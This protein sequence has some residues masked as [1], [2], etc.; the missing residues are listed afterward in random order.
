MRIL[1]ADD[2]AI[3][4]RLL[5]GT[6]RRLGHEIVAVADGVAARDALLAEGGP[7]LAILD[8]MMPGL[9]GLEVC[10]AV[11][12]SEGPYVYVILLTARA[13]RE[14][15]VA[16]LAAQA[17][18][19]LTKPFNVAELQARIQSGARIVDLQSSLLD[20]Q[21]ALRHEA[22]HDR[23]T[24][25]WNRGMIIDHLSRELA[26]EERPGGN[27]TVALVDLDHFKQINDTH[28]HEAGDEVLKETARRM[29]AALRD[30]DAAGRY[31]GEE[32]LVV[33]GAADGA[34]GLL[35]A[36]RV[37]VAIGAAPI[38]IRTTTVR[39]T[40]SVGVA[41]RPARQCDQA[42]LV[43][44]A[45]AALYRAKSRGRNCVEIASA[46]SL[47]PAQASTFSTPRLSAY[48]TTSV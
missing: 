20:T 44:A 30:V 37:R 13:Q 11:R 5:E 35:A 32:F 39:V 29:R 31:G 41:S 21:D 23:L 34:G 15:V 10:R 42:A 48:S 45:D 17:D 38:A 43:S 3:S 9:D 33:L 2:D 26:R 19:F 7:R 4:R 16:G 25:L 47:P 8:W 46:E 12:Q 14:D 27:V 1:I 18:E 6:L 40:A 22:T 28:G 36:D 24:G